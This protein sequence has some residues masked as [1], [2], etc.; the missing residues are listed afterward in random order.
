MIIIESHSA[1]VRG[2][3]RLEIRHPKADKRSHSAGVRGLKR[4]NAACSV[5]ADPSH[6]AGV[7]NGNPSRTATTFSSVG[8]LANSM[9]CA[10]EKIP[11]IPVRRV[12]MHK[13]IDEVLSGWDR[14]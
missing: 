9:M 4:Y 14:V 2:L 12:R 1:G 7:S 11:L 13:L 6:S 5:F 3:K 8:T 10:I